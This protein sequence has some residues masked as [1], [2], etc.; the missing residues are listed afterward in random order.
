MRA[1]AEQAEGVS[2]RAIPPPPNPPLPCSA[3]RM[4]GSDLPQR[5]GVGSLRACILMV[6]TRA[7][8]HGCT[9]PST[10]HTPRMGLRVC[11]QREMAAAGL[12]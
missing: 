12:L 4:Q 2:E 5:C 6:S 8:T 11:L 10:L 9:Q 3:V 1:G 7:A